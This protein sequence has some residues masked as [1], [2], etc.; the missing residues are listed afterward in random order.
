MSPDFTPLFLMSPDFTPLFLMSPDFT[1][2]FLM[3]PESTL[4]LP[5]S[6]PAVP[7][8]ASTSTATISAR[9]RPAPLF[10]RALRRPSP[11]SFIPSIK[12]PAVW[13]N[14]SRLTFRLLRGQT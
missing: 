5:L 4:F 10:S 12:T 11:I 2:L 14:T 9:P 3:S 1:W 7:L 6:A 13:L 8:I